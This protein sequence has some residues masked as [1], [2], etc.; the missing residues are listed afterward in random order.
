MKT[1]TDGWPIEEMKALEQFCEEHGIVGF[2][3]GRI[4]PAT[5]LA[6]LK[7]SMGIVDTQL[8]ERIP[9]NRPKNGNEKAVLHG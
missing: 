1:V 8:E 7:A 2:K 5:A 3:C 4:P 6:L 9:Y